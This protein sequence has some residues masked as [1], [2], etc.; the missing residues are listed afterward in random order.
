ME[1]CKEYKSMNRNEKKEYLNES[2]ETDFQL[3]LPQYLDDIEKLVKCCVKNVVCD[4][5]INSSKITVFGKSIISIMYL[6]SDMCPLSNV[7]EE[8]F[9]KSFDLSSDDNL[10]FADVNLS[11]KY[12]NFR[13][14]NQRR[15]DVHA[16]LNAH[17]CVFCK[18][19]SRYLSN[20]K[21]A[22]VRSCV[23]DSLADKSCGICGAEFDE[24][25]SVAGEN[26]RIK[27]IINT[28][29]NTIVEDK[30]IIKDKMLVKLRCEANV[31]YTNEKD[32]LEK[33]SHSF[34]LSKIIEAS[35]CEE[36]DKAFV[37]A[38][39]SK[40][41]VKAK[42][43]ANNVLCDIELVGKISISYKLFSVEKSEFITDSYIPHF[44]SSLES[45]TIEIKKN[46]QFFF[47]DKTDEMLFECDKNIVEIVDL[48]AEIT[49]CR[50]EK[51]VMYAQVL[52]SFIYYDD[53]SQ[54]CS[55]EKSRELSFT[56]SDVEADGEGSA[57]LKSYDFVIKN[58][59]RVSLRINFEYS[60]Y[61]YSIE[62]V[63]YLS[64]IESNGERSSINS[65]QLTL[66]FADKN[67]NVWDI[68]KSFSTDVDLIMQENELSSEILDA[69]RVLLVP[70]M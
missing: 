64:D 41:Y 23:V 43:N 13:L 31:L 16:S 51:S 5:E 61:L 36:E 24:T 67:E 53:T 54:L 34:S 33:S 2:F 27:N 50:V 17:I 65:P 55:Y 35:E 70:G 15:I 47:D 40:L 26:S 49:S 37:F 3:N 32:E 52:L 7:F 25:F 39:V 14:I 11:T 45:S 48:K 19:T 20:C 68:A 10:C 38:T 63:S 58:T 29:V 12:Y 69:K 60:A 44:D 18:N 21:N 28:F 62:R 59:D 1:L 66:Y 57:V 30:K 42:T 6:N 46:P 4:Y 9:S 22:F 8:E 56:L